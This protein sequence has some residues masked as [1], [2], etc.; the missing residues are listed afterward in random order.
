MARPPIIISNGGIVEKLA[1]D[2]GKET[3]DIGVAKKIMDNIETLNRKARN[4]D[5]DRP[6]VRKIVSNSKKEDPRILWC[7]ASEDIKY[8]K[9]KLKNWGC[10]DQQ[11]DLSG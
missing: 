4:D 7:L 3:S 10:R 11:A 9:G 2:C 1:K 8:L 6:I 5:S